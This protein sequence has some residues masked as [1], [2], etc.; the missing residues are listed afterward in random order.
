MRRKCQ[1]GRGATRW[2]VP[3]IN[4]S[5]RIDQ[6]VKSV[7]HCLQIYVAP[8]CIGCEEARALA[9][10]IGR[11]FAGVH[12]EVIDVQQSAIAVPATIF[13][14]PTYVWDGRVYSLGNPTREALVIMIAAEVGG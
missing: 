8:H 10:L 11:Q 14:T 4:S 1:A 3:S 5:R 9:E 7:E 13:A 6:T 2:L 12:V